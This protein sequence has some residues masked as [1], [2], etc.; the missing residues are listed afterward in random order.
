MNTF[1]S[2]K[3]IGFILAILL[4]ASS[5]VYANQDVTVGSDIIGYD[6]DEFTSRII[7]E[8]TYCRDV[9]NQNTVSLFVP[10]SSPEE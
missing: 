9:N 10:A 6:V 8:F 2:Y 7:T 5:S 1:K 3:K 4:I